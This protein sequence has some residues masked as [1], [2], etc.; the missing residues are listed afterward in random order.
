MSTTQP[1]EETT[2]QTFSDQ[3]HGEVLQPDDEGYDEAR[4]IW[5]AMIDKEPAVIARC[6]GTADVMTAVDFARDLSLRLAVKGG[7][8]NVAGTALCDDGLVIDLSPMD[9]VRVDPDTQTAR[10]QA[11]ATIG[12]L[13]HET[14]AFGLVTTGG[15]MSETGIAGLTLGGGLGYLAR[16]YGLAHDN[17]R[18]IDVV[19]ADGELVT[20]S[21]EEN[22]EL[23]WGLRGGAGNF[24]VVT[25]FEF[26]LHE[27]GPE[28]LNVRLMYPPD[29]IPDTLRFYDEFMR[30]A[31]NE[32]GCYAAILE[33]SPEYGLPEELHGV[34][35][36]AFRGL[37]AG[38][39]SEG[40]EAF[41]PLREFGDPI[42]DMT[43]PI[44]YTD[45]QQ[46][47]DDLYCAGHRNYW[48]SNFYDGISDGF[49][50]TLM[51]YTE[52]IPSP[53]STVF[54]EWMGGEIAERAEDAT[55]F[56]HRDKSFA[57][58]VA[59]KWTDPERD[60]E[61]I[62]WARE[63]H[64]SLEPYAADGVYVNYLSGDESERVPEA[65]GERYERLHALKREWDPDNL[66]Q[67]NQNIKP[68][69]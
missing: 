17:L 56:P 26:E 61:H 15:I 50:D 22:P 8:H 10:V 3:I 59:P 11:G 48:K 4:T 63:F 29:Q 54:F 32:V 52:S 30:E 46:Q 45:Y 13:D 24:G 20:A 40:K 58:T 51:E 28:I 27:L 64:Q 14:Q 33:G 2:I 55:A 53:Y 7:G 69:D 41:R 6:T 5:N 12:D 49:I 37:Y 16:E 44:P 39:V 38:D 67:T 34:T 42:T 62:R 19:T 47:A 43:Q 21:A 18:S 25:S 60:D 23:F 57:F 1:L 65:Y 66:F 68:A 31:P 9:S 35:L 36:L